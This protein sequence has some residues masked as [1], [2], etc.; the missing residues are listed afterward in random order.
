L[1]TKGSL[2]DAHIKNVNLGEVVEDPIKKE[3][4]KE[5]KEPEEELKEKL[6]I[7]KI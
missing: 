5:K 1:L 4:L 7:N 6:G 3:N 2:K